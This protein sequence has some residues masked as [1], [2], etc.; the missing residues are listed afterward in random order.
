M[1]KEWRLPISL[2][3]I[4]LLGHIIYFITKGN[5]EFLGYCTVIIILFAIIIKTDKVY[6]Y[7]IA[8][9]WLISIW[10][11][12]HSLGGS[13]YIAGTRAF[14]IVLI[15]ILGDP[16]FILKYDQFAHTFAFFTITI[17]CYYVLKKYIK[18]GKALFITTVL[19]ATGIGATYEIIEF[20]MVIFFDAGEAVGG[21]YNTVLDLV[22]NFTG[23]ILSVIFSRKV[24]DKK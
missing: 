5:F 16:F 6:N 22:F 10:V 3:A 20:A 1:K 15:N 11:V 13:V 24:L 8:S 21:Y 12:I 4:T 2:A 17:F 18:K 7:P 9:V 23:S 14:D 19:M